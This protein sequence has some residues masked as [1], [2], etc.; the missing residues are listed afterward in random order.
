MTDVCIDVC[1]RVCVCVYVYVFVTCDMAGISGQADLIGPAGG[2]TWASHDDVSH[3]VSSEGGQT[4]NP[5]DGSTDVA[6]R[7]ETA[8]R[9][10]RLLLRA[11]RND[12]TDGKFLASSLL[13]VLLL[14]L[15]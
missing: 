15:C 6:F 14:R 8:G 1:V 10:Q 7:P 4:S 2:P 9:R 3:F 5:Q 11:R 13:F 12:G